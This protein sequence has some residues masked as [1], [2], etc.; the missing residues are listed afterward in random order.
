MKIKELLSSED[1]WCQGSLSKTQNGKG[2][3]SFA[4][5]AVSWCLVG[6]IYKCYHNSIAC[7][8][9]M[10]LIKNELGDKVLEWNDDPTRKFEDVREL[11]ERLDI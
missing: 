11:V 1:K 2:C 5:E 6:A 3:F 9:V 7:S 4:E 8:S 10:F